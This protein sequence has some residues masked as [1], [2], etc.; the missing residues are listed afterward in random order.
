VTSASTFELIVRMV[1]SLAVVVGLMVGVTTFLKRKGLAGFA[2]SGPR[3]A[4]PGVEVEVLARRTLGRNASVAVVRAAGKGM[5]LG[6][7]DSQVT[8][9]GDAEI[10]E[11]E[12][13]TGDAQRTGVSIAGSGVTTPWKTMLEGLRDR[14]VR[15]P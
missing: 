4:V 12:L 2:P 8:L 7:T 9:L 5:V 13:E 15:R 1:L 11:L 6:V 10:D 3:R 14:T